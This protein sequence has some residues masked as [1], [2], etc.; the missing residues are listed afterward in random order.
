PRREQIRDE[1]GPLAL[2]PEEEQRIELRVLERRKPFERRGGRCADG[3]QAGAGAPRY[4]DRE[5]TDSAT[6]PSRRPASRPRRTSPSSDSSTAY[7]LGSSSTR[8]SPVGSRWQKRPR[9][10]PDARYET[11]SNSSPASSSDCSSARS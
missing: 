4:G 10:R 1:H 7:V 9:S 2:A 6:R 5:A 11:T 8:V 3:A